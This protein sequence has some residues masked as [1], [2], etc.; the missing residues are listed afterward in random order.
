[1]ILLSTHVIIILIKYGM[2]SV[3]IVHFM[4]IFFANILTQKST[5]YT[6]C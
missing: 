5:T 3:F 1:M 2:Q 4:S 6:S